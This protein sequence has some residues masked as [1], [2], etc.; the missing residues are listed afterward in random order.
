MPP[1][2]YRVLFFG[3][4][5]FAVPVLESLHQMESI[6][7]VG[8]FTQPD[9]PVGRKQILTPPPVKLAADKL[10][11]PIYQPTKLKSEDYAT[12]LRELAP[13]VIVIVAY[14]KII[15]EAAL[16]IPQ[17]GW[18]NVHASLLPQ[19]RGASPIQ[20][21]ILNGVKQTGITLMKLD[22]GLDTGPIISQKPIT[23][24]SADNSQ[25]LHNKLSRLGAE[26]ISE[27]LLP[28]LA[29]QLKPR[30]QD[31]SLATTTKI[32]EKENGRIVWN[33]SADFIARQIR[34]YTPW[35]GAFTTWGGKSL[36]ILEATV[37]DEVIALPPGKIKR[38]GR[39]L[40]VG[41]GSSVLEL[42]T[43]QLAGK[44]P[45]TTTEFL[46]GHP[47]FAKAKLE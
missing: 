12:Q 28:Y 5:E 32:I 8:V 37:Y 47:E 42:K 20:T 34:A 6:N 3:T 19:Y 17:Y 22:T 2:T 14:G 38:L 24:Q 30:P 41:T 40:L 11:L 9:K 21:A 7:L 26:L 16:T 44:K 31:N 43:L 35:P 18:V 13:D 29:G 25:T 15:P 23:I 39:T 46:N 10:A 27:S 36:K 45:Q 33:K 4:P 1:K